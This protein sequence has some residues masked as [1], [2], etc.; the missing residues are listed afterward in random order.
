[1]TAPR[2][3][4]WK[5]Y[6]LCRT[7]QE[8][9]FVPMREPQ[10]RRPVTFCWRPIYLIY[11]SRHPTVIHWHSLANMKLSMEHYIVRVWALKRFVILRTQWGLPTWLSAKIWQ[12]WVGFGYIIASEPNN[13]NQT[14]MALVEEVWFAKP[15]QTNVQFQM[16]SGTLSSPLKDTYTAPVTV[17]SDINSR[18]FLSHLAGLHVFD[19]WSV[20]N[21]ETR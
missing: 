14:Q 20:R 7:S 6:T 5:S 8:S 10:A 18:S 12:F 9:H 3:E 2:D 21:M 15:N 11:W 4:G 13:P 16:H 17:V 19:D 1:M